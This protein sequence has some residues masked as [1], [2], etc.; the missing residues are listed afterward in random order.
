MQLGVELACVLR[1]LKK[2]RNVLNIVDAKLGLA[3]EC[4]KICTVKFTSIIYV[5]LMQSL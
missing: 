1:Y 2:I 5:T 4:T 3:R